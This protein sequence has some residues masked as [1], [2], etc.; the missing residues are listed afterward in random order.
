MRKSRWKVCPADIAIGRSVLSSAR[1]PHRPYEVRAIER[2]RSSRGSGQGVSSICNAHSCRIVRVC[3]K[4]CRPCLVI[5]QLRTTVEPQAAA[6]E[7]GIA[8]LPGVPNIENIIELECCTAG[9]SI[10]SPPAP[11]PSTWHPLWSKGSLPRPSVP[12]QLLALDCILLFSI[13]ASNAPLNYPLPPPIPS[14][15]S[16]PSR[17]F[18]SIRN[19][20]GNG[21]VRTLTSDSTYSLLDSHHPHPHH[22]QP[23]IPIPHS[24][25]A[26]TA[27]DI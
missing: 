6:F 22:R 12:S 4:R 18:R 17:H 1:S 5:P 11:W 3:M 2:Q 27:D 15:T 25:G 23:P 16:P 24:P 8:S 21:V 20:A 10:T 13:T 19:L 14:S 26:S 7:F 9:R